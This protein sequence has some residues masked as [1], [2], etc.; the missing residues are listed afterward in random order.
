MDLR[1]HARFSQAASDRPGAPWGGG[2]QKLFKAFDRLGG[3]DTVPV[4]NRGSF[5]RVAL[6]KAMGIPG[7]LA[8]FEREIS[9]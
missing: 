5:Q 8:N 9:L 2:S 4:R 1:G 6:R 3:L 7:K